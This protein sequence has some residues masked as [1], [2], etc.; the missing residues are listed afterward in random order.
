MCVCVLLNLYYDCRHAGVSVAVSSYRPY[1]YSNCAT[2]VPACGFIVIAC[3][4]ALMLARG[5]IRNRPT[6]SL[7][8]QQ[9]IPCLHACMQTYAYSSCKDRWPPWYPIEFLSKLIIPLG[10]FAEFQ[11]VSSQKTLHVTLDPHNHTY[12]Q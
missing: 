10:S 9:N 11:H 6:G 8:I 4:R 5:F 2:F 7:R 1:M 3:M 12:T